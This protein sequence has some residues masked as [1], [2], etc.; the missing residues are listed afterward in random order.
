V[1]SRAQ[2]DAL[3]EIECIYGQA[4]IALK[5]CGMTSLAS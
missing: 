1:V 4:S 5:K 3:N 2:L